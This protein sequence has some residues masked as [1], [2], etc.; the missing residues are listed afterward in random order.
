MFKSN[1]KDCGDQ[2]LIHIYIY[3]F[4]NVYVKTQIYSPKTLHRLSHSHFLFPL[5][6]FSFNDFL[7]WLSVQ[8]KC[9]FIRP[10]YN[11]FYCQISDG[12][13]SVHYL[14][15]NLVT[16][17]WVVSLYKL[18]FVSKRELKIYVHSFILIVQHIEVIG[19]FFF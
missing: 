13:L 16:D 18:N 2:K 6:I 1:K 15:N 8:K 9:V 17:N 11:E 19:T 4:T 12:W 10:R 7:I 14:Y 5:D 3:K